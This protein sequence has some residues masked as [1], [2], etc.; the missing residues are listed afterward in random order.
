[1]R[2]RYGGLQDLGRVVAV[3][4]ADGTLAASGGRV[5]KNVAGYDLQKLMTGALGTLG[6]IAQATFR[7]HPLPVYWRTL[8]LPASEIEDLQ[9]MM[10]AIQDSQAAHAALQVRIGS[11]ALCGLDVRLEGPE[12]GVAWQEATIRALAGESRVEPAED[13]VWAA[14]E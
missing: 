11:D 7:V 14:R 4:L 10:L 1:L 3:A 5:L 9:R 12:A 6:V 8:T 2:L 13:G